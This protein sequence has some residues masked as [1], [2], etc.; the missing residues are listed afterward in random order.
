M[1][2]LFVRRIGSQGFP[3]RGELTGIPVAFYLRQPE[4]KE[5]INRER[6]RKNEDHIKRRFI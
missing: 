1:S 5:K 3:Y 6:K 4:K 2:L